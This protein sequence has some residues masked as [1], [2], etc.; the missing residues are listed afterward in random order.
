MLVVGIGDIGV[1]NRNA[2]LLHRGY[3]AK[4]DGRG[5]AIK[6]GKTDETIWILNNIAVQILQWRIRADLGCDILVA[7]EALESAIASRLVGQ[8]V[9]PGVCRVAQCIPLCT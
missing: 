2:V 1:G 3:I 8:Y 7:E 4:R 6:A 9:G 5:H